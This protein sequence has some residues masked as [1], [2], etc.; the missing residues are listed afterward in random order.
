MSSAI[1]SLKRRRAGLV[2]R[3]NK[4]RADLKRGLDRDSAE[5]ALQL[6][7][8][9]VLLEIERVTS[10]ELASVEEQIAQA[11]ADQL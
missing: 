9:E 7:N 1:D 8:Y 3:L 5:Q 4:I 6:E 2:E 11:Q 10:E